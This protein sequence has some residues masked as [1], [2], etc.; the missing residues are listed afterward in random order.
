M[1]K[2]SMTYFPQYTETIIPLTLQFCTVIDAACDVQ[3]QMG[4]YELELCLLSSKLN[5]AILSELGG[6]LFDSMSPFSPASTRRARASPP[7]RFAEATILPF[8]SP[9]GN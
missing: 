3:Y 9:T 5:L 8:L 4:R 2:R 1:S 6:N 7:S